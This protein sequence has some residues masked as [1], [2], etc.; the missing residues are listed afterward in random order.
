MSEIERAES[1]ERRERR[2]IYYGGWKRAGG[3][4][5]VN[6]VSTQPAD[7][8]R[9]GI[10]VALADEIGGDFLGGLVGFSEGM[11][12]G[13]W[14]QRHDDRLVRHVH[15][16]R[17]HVLLLVIDLISA[18][19]LLGHPEEHESGSVDGKGLRHLAVNLLHRLIVQRVKV[20][21]GGGPEAAI[22]FADDDALGNSAVGG[23]GFEGVH[24]RIPRHF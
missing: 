9:E 15:A 12:H 10:L 3:S 16:Q 18:V 6:I 23:V 17:T 7:D 21:G 22:F 19:V 8:G 2:A 1:R 14:R 5:E 20:G 13:V 11:G 24:V 4:K